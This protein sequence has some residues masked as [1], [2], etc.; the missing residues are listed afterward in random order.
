MTH[1]VCSQ[2]ELFIGIDVAKDTLD[3]ARSNADDTTTFSNNVRGIK[4]LLVLLRRVKPAL[5]VI[6]AT[7][8]Y[9]QPALEAMLDADLPV[10]LAQPAHVRHMAKGLGVLA[11]TDSIDAHILV[12]FGRHAAPR[13]AEK[14][15]KHRVELEALITC[16]RQLIK[17]RIEQRNRLDVTR[18][19]SASR[20]I[21]KVLKT[22]QDQI[23]SLDAQIRKII[24]SDD[25]LNRWDRLLRTVPG[26]GAVL[27]TTLLAELIELGAVGRTQIS[28]LVGVAPFN[29][30]SGRFRG[31][32]KIQGGR[33]AVRSAL[34]MATITA[35][36]CNPVI[37]AFAQRLKAAGKPP[38][39]AI[40]AAMRKL[41]TLL[42]A[43][44]RD[45]LEW[46]QLKV[47]QKMA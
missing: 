46:Q 28:A 37:R 23:D 22:V 39:V 33:P 31:K 5:I 8:G 9:E 24:E 47:V 43:M 15:S 4:E 26:V 44:M 17:V 29:R 12:K 27:S 10:A 20:A 40:V 11:K 21:E 13:L 6:E 34:Y 7:G 30:D 42:N 36:R 16:R 3:L 14:R 1:S 2:D 19:K 38:K 18:F 32:R 45:Q 25:D 35:I 41:I